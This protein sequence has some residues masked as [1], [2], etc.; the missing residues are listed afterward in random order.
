MYSVVVCPPHTFSF[1]KELQITLQQNQHFT[2]LEKNLT[3]VINRKEVVF[4][5]DN[6]RLHIA[7]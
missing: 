1:Y 7:K 3:G 5:Q 2:K 6:A 4:L